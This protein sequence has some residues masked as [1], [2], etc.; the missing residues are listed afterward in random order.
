M[1]I[2]YDFDGNYIPWYLIQHA[3]IGRVEKYIRR[4]FFD[5]INDKYISF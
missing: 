3:F 1:K 2:T 4:I 5:F